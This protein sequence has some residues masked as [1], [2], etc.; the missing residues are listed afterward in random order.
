MTPDI[1]KYA[2]A[3]VFA[4]LQ[5]MGQTYGGRS[6][7]QQIPYIHHL[8]SVAAEV[9][10]GI[11]GEPGWDVDLA[12]QCALLHDVIEDTD[13]S[14]DVVSEQF[15]VAVARRAS[16]EQGRAAR[17]QHLADARQ[18][19]PDT[20]GTERGVGGQIG[21]PHRQLVPPAV[22]LERGKNCSIPDRS[23]RYP[24]RT[25]FGQPKACRPAGR[26]DCGIRRLALIATANRP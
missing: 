22:L 3:W 17:H 18:P 23:A 15:G 5:H 21:R 26:Q 16:L 19:A 4:T 2:R 7:D 6:A 8:A 10:W 24:R 13:A 9:T 1:D 14:F 20:A 12:I 25:R 11:A